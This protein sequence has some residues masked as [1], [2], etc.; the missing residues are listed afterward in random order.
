[1]WDGATILLGRNSTVA[2]PGRIL[3]PRSED[4]VYTDAWLCKS[5]NFNGPRNCK[6]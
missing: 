4:K 1:M 3:Q 6:N 2:I 5:P